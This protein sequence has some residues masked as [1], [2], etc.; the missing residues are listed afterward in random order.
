M[1]AVQ[2]LLMD[3]PR[4]RSKGTA[5]AEAWTP[6]TVAWMVV[7]VWESTTTAGEGATAGAARVVAEAGAMT[8]PPGAESN[9]SWSR[10]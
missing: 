3:S 2:P 4:I 9:T 5:P 7:A 8:P 1:V 10:S 6:C